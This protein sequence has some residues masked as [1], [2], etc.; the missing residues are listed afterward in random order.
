MTVSYSLVDE[1]RMCSKELIMF[2]LLLRKKYIQFPASQGHSEQMR[3][4]SHIRTDCYE[5][6][7]K[8]SKK[9][10]SNTQWLVEI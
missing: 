1:F 6:E 8:A 5:N 4:T 7:Q 3:S 10:T 2:K 9:G